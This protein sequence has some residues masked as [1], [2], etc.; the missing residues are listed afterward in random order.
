MKKKEKTYMMM[1]VTMMVFLLSI[2]II[3]YSVKAKDHTKK[4]MQVTSVKIEEGDTLWRIAKEYYTKECKSM[5]AYVKEIKRTNG[6]LT[7][8]IHEGNYII[9][10]HYVVVD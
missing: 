2:I 9:I 3:P 7:D 5:K 10:P 1:L 4:Q 6:L 8:T